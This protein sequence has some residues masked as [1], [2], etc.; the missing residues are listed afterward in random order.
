MT[1]REFITNIDVM[2][3]AVFVETRS[4]EK[5]Y[6]ILGNYDQITIDMIPEEVLNRE[7]DFICG[8]STKH[9]IAIYVK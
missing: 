3:N 7:V 8:A 6:S 9:K 1:V 2:D 5:L 4:I